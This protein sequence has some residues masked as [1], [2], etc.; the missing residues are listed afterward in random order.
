LKYA[1][2][3]KAY[4]DTLPDEEEEEEPSEEEKIVGS[5]LDQSSEVVSNES[6]V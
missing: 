6:S 5:S 1:D 4:V 2:L 3:K